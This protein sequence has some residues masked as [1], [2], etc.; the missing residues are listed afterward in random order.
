MRIWNLL[1]NLSKAKVRYNFIKADFKET[2]EHLDN[3]SR[4]WYQIYT[5][6]AHEKP[7]FSELSWCIDSEEKLVLV[8]INIGAYREQSLDEMALGH[9]RGILR[10][11][12]ECEKDI[13][14]RIVYDHMGNALE[15]EPFFFTRVIEH[16]NQLVPVINEYAQAIFVYQG[17]LIG[18]WGEMHTSRF[19]APS[20]IKEMWNILR[21]GLDKSIYLAVRRPVFWRILHPEDC[22]RKVLSKDNTGLFD[23]AIFG[24][25]N[26]LGTFGME[27]RVNSGWE[28]S[29]IRADEL[30]FEEDLCKHA[31]NG[32]E[33]ICGENYTQL[34]NQE[35]TIDVLKQMHITYLNNAYDPAILEVWKNWKCE[36]PGIWQEHSFYDY[37]GE[38]LGYRFWV[39]DA[40]VSLKDKKEEQ[41]V[42]TITMENTGFANIYQETELQ[43]VRIN[44]AGEQFLQEFEYDMRELNSGSVQTLSTE[45]HAENCKLYLSARIKKNGKRIYFSNQSE[46]DA[47]VALGQITDVQIR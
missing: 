20:K 21:Y 8:I 24:S 39:K 2:A 28:S 19:M 26:H 44:D 25:E 38:H 12:T 47:Y 30:A 1:C 36:V 6:D 10:F 29:W 16:L 46:K 14:L 35:T 23:D 17:M 18:N 33:A 40:T 11:F 42:V 15:K 22:G 34:Y 7:D 9:I 5:F 41:L 13:V 3:P 31:P 43:L 37:A 32:G 27:P 45:I 4:G